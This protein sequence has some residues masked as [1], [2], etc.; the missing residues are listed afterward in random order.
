MLTLTAD[1]WN[2]FYA[3]VT[4]TQPPDLSQGNH[5]ELINI[6]TYGARRQA[7]G[8][9]GIVDMTPAMYEVMSPWWYRPWYW[10]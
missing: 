1:E 4:G 6:N 3:Q 7:A 8:L 5:N 9:S 10:D 2:Y